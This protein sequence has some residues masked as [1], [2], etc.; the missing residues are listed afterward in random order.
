MES[1][2]RALRGYALKRTDPHF[3][4]L[5]RIKNGHAQGW[6]Q[7]RED[8]M[9]H[10]VFS[11]VVASGKTTLINSTLI[12]GLR[13]FPDVNLLPTDILENT[14]ASTVIRLPVPSDPTGRIQV[15]YATAKLSDLREDQAPEHAE[16]EAE[17]C[18]VD[19]AEAK[20]PQLEFESVEKLRAAMCEAQARL[21]RSRTQ[22]DIKRMIITMP[23][24]VISLSREVAAKPESTVGFQLQTVWTW[25]GPEDSNCPC[26]LVPGSRVSQVVIRCARG[27][28]V[29]AAAVP[30]PPHM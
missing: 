29:A 22:D 18:S 7:I 21:K 14:G 30:R 1:V 3:Q 4:E 19:D 25:S 27:F 28:V 8:D 12:N 24:Q 2:V 26:Q 6:G 5:R 20:A 9:I 10:I 17:Q 15:E 11:G 23:Y 16:P 13:D